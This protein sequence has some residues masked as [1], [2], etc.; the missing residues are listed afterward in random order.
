MNVCC[1]HSSIYEVAPYT[2]EVKFTLI[3]PGKQHMKHATPQAYARYHAYPTVREYD[4]TTAVNGNEWKPDMSVTLPKSGTWCVCAQHTHTHARIHAC[5]PL[6][7]SCIILCMHAYVHAY[8]QVPTSTQY[9]SHRGKYA[10][11]YVYV[12]AHVQ[13]CD[14]T[15]HGFI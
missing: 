12:C 4:V 2:S 15:C 11:L 1:I 7:I 9:A 14:D 13:M 6:F 10:G 3:S 5:M 8:T